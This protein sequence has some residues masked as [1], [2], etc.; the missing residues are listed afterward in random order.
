MSLRGFLINQHL[1]IAHE[2]SQNVTGLLFMSGFV[3][4]TAFNLCHNSPPASSYGET[5][6]GTVVTYFLFLL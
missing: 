3:S 6:R 2:L 5:V 4:T 1:I